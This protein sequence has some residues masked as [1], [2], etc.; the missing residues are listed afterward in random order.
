[1]K[2]TVALIAHDIHDNGGMERA[3]AELVRHTHDEFDFTIVSAELTP[4]LRSLVHRWIR[5]RVPTR[6]APLRFA[7]FWLLAGRKL[8]SLDVDIA[9]SVGAI[10]PNRVDVAA[11]H[12][13][14]AG[15]VRAQG[16]LAPRS[17]PLIRRM[18]TAVARLLALAAERWCYAPGRLRAFAAVSDGV[19]EE[20]AAH[21]PGVKVRVIP[22]GVDLDRFRPD[23]S[24]R[25]ELRSAVGLTDEPVAIFV[26][27]DWDR[28]GLAIG[29]QALAEVRGQGIALQ[30][31]IV[32]RGDH[33][34]FVALANKWGVASAVAFFGE[35]Y[36]V[37]HFLAAADMLILPSL[38]ETFSLVGFEAAATGLPIVVTRVHGIGD[39]VRDEGGGVLVERTTA[40][41]ANALA[42]VARDPNLRRCLGQQALLGSQKYSWTAST[43][44]VA[45]LYR[46]LLLDEKHDPR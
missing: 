4:E 7:M 46:S 10:V 25:A 34:R 23:A 3:C 2:P 11:V 26:G 8:R 35:R 39:L 22:N 16:Y 31:W 32:G 21:Y 37:E 27:G 24:A 45:N 40:S 41:V 5:V 44:S 18:N 20:L 33:D 12:F 1:V 38:Y 30:L 15:F 43:G 28:K 29:I 17:A 6:P 14:H 19:R 9:H 13:C 36:D 42:T